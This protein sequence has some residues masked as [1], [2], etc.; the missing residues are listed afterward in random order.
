MIKIVPF[1]AGFGA[2]I[3]HLDISAVIG[4]RSGLTV[5]DIDRL[6]SAFDRHRLLFIRCPIL[7]G[8]HQVAFAA[9]F[10]R[11]VPESSLWGYVS[12]SRPDGVVGEGPLLYHS[13]FAF[14]PDPIDAICL[15]ALEM[16]SGGSSTR[17]VDAVG[18]VDRL[19]AP[20]RSRL[21]GLEVL[22]CYDLMQEGDHRMRIAD[23]D[24]RSPRS[25]HP[26]IAEHPR[27]GDPVIMA[28]AMHTDSILGM[29]HEESEE[30]L[31]QIFDVLYDPDHVVE[32]R[33]SIG[34]LVIW[35]NRALQHGRD[36]VESTAAR[37]LQRV[38][39]GNYTP[40]ELLPD[41][42][43]LLSEKHDGD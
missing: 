14:T 33:W 23:I 17:W 2:E 10:G 6:R 9:R 25:I 21:A 19:P 3:T 29:P 32:H 36:D 18:A 37:T 30:L 20:L 40:A 41:L 26:V 4:H 31:G 35:D 42:D 27:T 8:E 28:S 34:D 39:L 12:N 7:S 43:A 38:T 11:L 1:S 5:A 22:N 15:H 24:P 13:D 16:P